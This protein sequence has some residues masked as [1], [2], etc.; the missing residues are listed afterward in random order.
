MKNIIN[1]YY[2]IIVREYKKVSN[3]Y[4]FLIDEYKYEFIPCFFDINEILKISSIAYINNRYIYEII[5]NKNNE[6][7]TIFDNT[8]HIL[9]KKEIL[10]D[11]DYNLVDIYNYDIILNIKKNI[12]W[13]E[14]WIN[15]IDYYN[16][17]MNEVGIN[18]PLLN[19]S[20]TYYVGLSE[21]AINI[22]NYVNY[23]NIV[24]T[25]AHK[26]IEKKE[27]LYDPLNII[28]DTKVRDI[29]EYIKKEFFYGEIKLE[30]IKQF[31]ISNIISKDEI[32]LLI[33][34]LIYPS[35]YFDIYEQ[36]FIEKEEKKDLEKII[37][38]N[39]QYEVFL[40]TFYNEI[41]N[42]YKLPRIEFLEY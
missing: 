37:K 39:T 19:K 12:N 23:D 11:L 17:Q 16:E 2:N 4:E 34:R 9:I 26:R 36:I 32:M 15:K 30:E 29:A 10:R 27:D 42:L 1:Y 25:F 21:L 13:K 8:P 40:K 14:L 41:K 33:A 35:Y 7:I 22:L 5:K 38:K 3:K 24:N 28:I 31:I 20:F 6:F 18:Y